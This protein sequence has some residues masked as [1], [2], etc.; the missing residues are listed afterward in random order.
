MGGVLATRLAGQ[1]ELYLFDRERERLQITANKLGCVAVTSLEEAAAVGIVILAVPDREVVDCIK[2]FNQMSQPLIVINIAT[3]VTQLMLEQVAAEH[4][5]C[6]GVKFVGQ[7][8]EMAEGQRPVI[9]IDEQPAALVTLA[10]TIFQT[11]GQVMTGRADV[12]AAINTIAAKKA[13]EA[14]VQIEESLQC[15][16]ITE[17]A[18]VQSAIRQVAAGILKAYADG[19]MGP[20]ARDIIADIRTKIK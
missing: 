17:R 20:F 5:Q 12:V 2:A 18:I 10:K 7:A 13:L 16:H 14:A 1:V 15:C 3:N 9:I 6:I 11:V 19:T 8:G 4:I